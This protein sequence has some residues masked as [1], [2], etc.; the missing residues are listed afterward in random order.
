[1]S[2]GPVGPGG[3]GSPFN[4]ISWNIVTP[5]DINL[6]PNRT[7]Y[8][9]YTVTQATSTSTNYWADAELDPGGVIGGSFVSTT[10]ALFVTVSSS[11][12]IRLNNPAILRIFTNREMQT[13]TM[14]LLRG[15]TQL[16][17]ISYP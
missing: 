14:D 1:M 15:Y 8:I 16:T 17:V 5:T 13:D 4:T 7:Y 6:A 3:P 9:N 2:E 12:T 11:A 10:G